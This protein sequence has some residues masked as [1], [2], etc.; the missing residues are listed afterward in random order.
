[1]YYGKEIFFVKKFNNN[2]NISMSSNNILKISLEVK[3]F[4]INGLTRFLRKN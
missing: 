1:M 2:N 4:P 3:G